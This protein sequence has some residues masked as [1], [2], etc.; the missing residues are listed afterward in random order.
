MAYPYIKTENRVLKFI[1]VWNWNSSDNKIIVP[2][3][4][5]MQSHSLKIYLE[6]HAND[7][8]TCK[9]SNNIATVTEE[10]MHI[11]QS[12]KESYLFVAMG[13]PTLWRA[14]ALHKVRS[15]LFFGPEIINF[16]RSV[17]PDYIFYRHNNIIIAMYTEF[18]LVNFH[19]R[20]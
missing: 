7:L 15:I 16:I 4:D 2:D 20:I 14:N 18:H 3:H 17:N 1:K 9:I 8:S 5:S 6:G 13:D 10:I 19:H 11:Y 12:L